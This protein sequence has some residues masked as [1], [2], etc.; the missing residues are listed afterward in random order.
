METL[1]KKSLTE[2][3][4][5]IRANKKNEQQFISKCLQEIKE[6]LRLV[7]KKAKMIAVQKL[8]YVSHMIQ[9]NWS[10]K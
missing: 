6:E 9:Y 3:V 8:T 4:R 7:N 1:F 10:Y 5:G 2:L